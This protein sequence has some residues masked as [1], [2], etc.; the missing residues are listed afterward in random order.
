[1]KFTQFLFI[2]FTVL[3]LTACTTTSPTTIVTKEV[4]VVVAAP[5]TLYNCPKV[6]TLPNPDTLTNRD[7]ANLITRLSYNN[8]VCAANMVSIR[9]Y[10]AK[11]K[12]AIAAKNAASAAGK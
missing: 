11:A 4:S 1:M 6:G 10:V 7:L 3:S 8:K 12:A 2:S 5:D 9:N